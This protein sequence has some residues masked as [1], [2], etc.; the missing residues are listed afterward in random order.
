MPRPDLELLGINH[1]R[2]PV[3]AIGRDVY[4]DTRLILSKLDAAPVSDRLFKQQAGNSVRPPLG[5]S[6][7]DRSSKASTPGTT[8][9][10]REHITNAALRALLESYTTDTPLFRTLGQL[11]PTDLPLLSGPGAD[12]YFADRAQWAGGTTAGAG[13]SSSS[14]GGAAGKA[15]AA[16]AVARAAMQRARPAAVAEARRAFALLED[17]L[18]ADGR[19][20]ILGSGSASGSSSAAAGPTLADIDAVWPFH[21]LTGIPGAL[22]GA[23]ITPSTF[24]LVHAWVARFQRA[25]SEAKRRPG[26]PAPESI[27]GKEAARRIWRAQFWEQA[28]EDDGRSGTQGEGGQGV[29]D[30]RDPVVQALGLR[31]GDRIQ[32]VPTDSG[33]TH[34][35]VGR[36]WAIDGTEVVLEIDPPKGSVGGETIRLHAPRHG[37]R[38]TKVTSDERAKM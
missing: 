4:L 32:I 26:Y 24:P 37:F 19:E 10:S 34:P 31:R 36:L 18:L 30:A 14:S 17:T 9:T 8:G 1:R 6:A 23:D 2:I 28:Q 13:S 22:S 25:V 29:I 7:R 33:R 15:A 27:D 38:V 3:L 35:D 11:L 5:P 12:E 21:W 20:W 16:A